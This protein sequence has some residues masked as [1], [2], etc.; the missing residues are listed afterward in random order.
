MLVHPNFDPVVFQVGPLAIQ[1]YGLMYVFGFAGVYAAWAYRLRHQATAVNPRWNLDLASDL[2]FYGALGAVLGGRLGYVFF[3]K[4][5]EYLA[6]PISIVTGIRDGGMSF[7]GGLIGVIFALWLFSK[8]SKINFVEIGDFVAPV[9]PIGL[10]FGRIGNFIN[11]EL[12]GKPTDL[13]WGMVFTT[14]DGQARHPSMLYEALLEGL[15]LF[16]ILWLFSRKKRAL[17]I[18]S[19]MFLVGYA[20]ARMIVE[21]VRVPDRHLDYLFLDWVTMGQ[22]LSLP[23]LVLG[24]TLIAF[25]KKR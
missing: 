16:V 17:G 7:H 25:S 2:L 9:A 19:G 5:L 24:L 11:Q 6:D 18:L 12:W 3:Y 23:M 13:P 1:W 20:C 21:L 15:L 10:F 22:L 4:P 14:A 8:K